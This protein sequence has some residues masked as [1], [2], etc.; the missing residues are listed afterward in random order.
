MGTRGDTIQENIQSRCHNAF[1]CKGSFLVGLLFVLSCGL[2]SPEG[3]N[4]EPIEKKP[5]GMPS[6]PV[7]TSSP[8]KRALIVAISQ[9]K[10]STGWGPLASNHDVP[11]IRSA[12]TRHGFRDEQIHEVPNAQA[13]REGIVAA[14]KTSFIEPAQAGDI[15]VFHYSGHGQQLTDDD[16]DEELDGYDEALVPYDAP[17]CP[18]EIYERGVCVP[19]NYHGEKH[20]RDD[21]LNELVETLRQKVGPTGNVVIFL[22][23]CHSGTGI[24]GSAT[25]RGGGKPIGFPR[26]GQMRG[27]KPEKASGFFEH[28]TTARG[29]APEKDPYRAPYILFA[30]A[31]HDQLAFETE[32]D[33]GVE[34]GSLTYGVSRALTQAG[35][36]TSYRE[37]FDHVQWALQGRV[38]N[39]PQGEGAIDYEIFSGQ[40]IS[41]APY[42]EVELKNQDLVLKAGTLAGLLPGSQVEFHQVGTAQPTPATKLGEAEV[43]T[44]TS[45]AATMKMLGGME[46]HKVAHSWAFVTRYAFGDLRL[47][48][49]VANL[50]NAALKE[51]IEQ[52]LQTK[53]ATADLVMAKPDILI[54]LT[55]SSG[56]KD[57]EIIVKNARLGT[58]ILGPLSLT[59]KDL[60]DQIGNRLIDYARN[61]YLRRLQLKG[62][63]LDVE[64]EI[65]PVS[66]KKSCEG[67]AN[68]DPA[69]CVEKELKVEGFQS[70]GN[71][72]ELPLG[73]WFQLRVRPSNRDV[74]VSILDLVPDGTIGLLWPPPRTQDKTKFPKEKPKT[75][76]ALYQIAEPTGQEVFLLIA[77]EEWINFEPFVT[78]ESLRARGK[79]PRGALGLFAPLFDDLSVR[80]RAK[81][82]FPKGKVVTHAVTVTVRP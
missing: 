72:L 43:D 28:S 60:A 63:K 31:R 46:K 52:T 71:R 81:A 49:E 78:Q 64:F 73:T 12:L 70:P 3:A 9:Y 36:K 67:Q 59:D 38:T 55:S 7:V 1:P 80:T 6:S 27:T 68:P 51:S 69:S 15:V 4:G 30:A 47:K 10:P 45:L 76:P 16:Q 40:A 58:T 65:V 8:Q 62:S 21:E 33:D 13:T 82:V 39:E 79:T 66:L 61:Q 50:S 37:L 25:V 5:D 2:S 57:E 26:T 41:Q 19:Q 23:S 44:S 48:V 32:T 17:L 11:L 74:H 34:V 56:E 35:K 75:L 18:G 53:F 54:Q 24:R 42:I 22:D 29:V 77:T 20:L 14:F